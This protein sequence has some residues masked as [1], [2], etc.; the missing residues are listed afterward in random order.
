MPNQ[1]AYYAVAKGRNTG[2]YSSWA[3]CEA[4]V[5]GQQVGARWELYRKFGVRDMAEDFLTKHGTYNSTP[6]VYYAVAKGLNIGIYSTWKECEAQV[7]RQAGAL[8]GRF[9]TRALAEDYLLKN[10]ASSH[11]APTCGI[12]HAAATLSPLNYPSRNPK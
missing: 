10:G 6:V 12:E 3:E 5:K 11:L 8:Y 9:L 7:N 1:T 4:Q 2:I